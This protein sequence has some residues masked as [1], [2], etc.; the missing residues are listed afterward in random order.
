MRFPLPLLSL[1]LLA[2]AANS[3][4]VVPCY[5]I[6]GNQVDVISSVPG[7]PHY[8]VV[9]G[10]SVASTSIGVFVSDAVDGSWLGEAAPPPAIH[11][12]TE[13]AD[14]FAVPGPAPKRAPEKST[15]MLF[16]AGVALAIGSRLRP[17]R[18]IRSGRYLFQ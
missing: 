12:D 8:L 7:T 1:Y 15:V 6:L 2:S 11:L 14:L 13:L 3:A 10:A 4:S 18:R 9:P 5:E 17:T 16:A